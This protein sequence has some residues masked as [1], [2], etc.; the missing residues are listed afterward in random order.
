MNKDYNDLL[1]MTNM[2]V[3]SQTVCVCIYLLIS[4]DKKK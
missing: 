2:L 3:T 1:W 4:L